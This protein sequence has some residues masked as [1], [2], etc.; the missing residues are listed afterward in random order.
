[1]QK[2]NKW[3]TTESKN[4]KDDLTPKLEDHIFLSGFIPLAD[5]IQFLG[6]ETSHYTLFLRLY[7]AAHAFVDVEVKFVSRADNQ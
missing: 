4:K 5:T 7:H 6:V 3:I 1:M 2:S